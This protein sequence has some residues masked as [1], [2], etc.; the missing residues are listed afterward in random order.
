MTFHQFGLR[1]RVPIHVC[2]INQD[3]LDELLLPLTILP[4]HDKRLVTCCSLFA[5]CHVS[6]LTFY[7]SRLPSYEWI[8]SSKKG[9][10]SQGQT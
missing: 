8:N 4:F 2:L 10:K 1:D 5:Y 7:V 3:A 6:R 9:I